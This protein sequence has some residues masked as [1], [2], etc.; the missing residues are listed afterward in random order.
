VSP[1]EIVDLLEASPYTAIGFETKHLGTPTE[2]KLSQAEQY[3]ESIAT[4]LANNVKTEIQ[5]R[6]G[7]PDVVIVE[8]AKKRQVQAIIMCSESYPRLKHWIFGSIASRVVKSAP[9][10]VLLIPPSICQK[11]L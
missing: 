4:S 6:I 8:I 10:P 1:Q 5:V 3:I 2:R 7:H 9:C 11:C